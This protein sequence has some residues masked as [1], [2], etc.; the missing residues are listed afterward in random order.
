MRKGEVLR[1]PG[2]AT[3][4]VWLTGLPASGKSTIATRLQNVLRS[5]S[6]HSLILDGDEIRRILT[7]N[8]TYSDEE[9][10]RFYRD[11]AE[12]AAL[13]SAQGITPIVAATAPQ[14]AHRVFARGLVQ[15]FIEVLLVADREVLEERDPKGLYADAKEGRVPRLPGRGAPYE[16]PEQPS[17]VFDTGV[18]SADDVATAIADHL[19]KHRVQ[20]PEVVAPRTVVVGTDFSSLSEVA[21]ETALIL[22]RD[23]GVER[24]HLVHVLDRPASVAYGYPSSA[25]SDFKRRQGAEERLARFSAGDPRVG[26]EV[27]VG[28]PA[29]DLA[30]AAQEQGADLIVIAS[31]GRGAVRRALLG[32]VAASLIRTADVPMLIV[33]RDRRNV[34]FKHVLAAVDLSPISRRVVEVAETYAPGRVKIVSS[35]EMPLVS[36]DDVLPA[37]M[38][39]EERA[40]DREARKEQLRTL[41][42]K[43]GLLEGTASTAILQAAEDESADLIVIG[44]SGHNAWHRAFVGSTATHVVAAAECPVLVV[45]QVGIS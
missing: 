29:R 3:P 17:L 14:R 39:P 45:P 33:G 10:E 7:P 43:V 22:A 6:V 19:D 44:T 41:G 9:R 36:S 26:R 12:L 42:P 18:E 13:V 35:F 31:R 15:K 5:R 30:T 16:V 37:Y 20:P 25:E 28:I 21:Y 34:D 8:P 38:T 23:T 4:V 1:S 40:Q 11:L 27:R 2:G 24:I 32:S